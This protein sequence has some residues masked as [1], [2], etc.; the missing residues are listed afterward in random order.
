MTKLRDAV[1]QLPVDP[2]PART[3]TDQSSRPMQE[4]TI[5]TIHFE[6]SQRIVALT[7]AALKQ[8]EEDSVREMMIMCL[9]KL[10]LTEL[11][12]IQKETQFKLQDR[13]GKVHNQ[14]YLITQDKERYIEECAALRREK[15]EIEKASAQLK[16]ERQKFEQASVQLRQEKEQVE[17]AAT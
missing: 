5:D 12:Q 17:K 11:Y 2:V 4:A 3:S 9:D 10:S 16:A 14:L 8:R 13:E 6:S 15:V 1:T 7:A